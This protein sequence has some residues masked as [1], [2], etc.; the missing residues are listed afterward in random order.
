M[1]KQSAPENIIITLVQHPVF[2]VLFIPYF[3]ERQSESTLLLVEQA[4]HA[5]PER[6]SLL[7]EAERTI[8]SLAASYSE[9]ELMAIFS[10]EKVL[11]Q[12]LK[13]VTESQ[14]K[15]KIR[16]AIEKK[17]QKITELI[18]LNNIP[19]FSN[20]IGNKT[21]Y[22]YNRIDTSTEVTE[23]SFSFRAD[24]EH[25][26]YSLDCHRG[27]Q[28]VSLRE[29]K[30][31]IVINS[32]PA[33]LLFSTELHCFR[34][35]SASR[36]LPFTNKD[37]VA[38]DASLMD[39]YLE[40]I[41]LPVLRHHEASAT[42]LPLIEEK[43]ECKPLLSVG[44]TVFDEFSL[45]LLFTY[46]DKE[47][48]PGNP[49][50]KYVYL[51]KEND[52]T[53][54]RYFYRDTE[55]ENQLIEKLKAT[56]LHFDGECTFTAT[57]E[58]SGMEFREWLPAH[59]ELFT[60]E[61]RLMNQD[62]N[63]E[64]SPEEIEILE[65]LNEGNDWFE[66]YI[67][68]IVGKHRIPFNRFRKNILEGRREYL[69]PDGKFILLP[70]EW[71]SKYADLIEFGEMVEKGIRVKRSYSGIVQEAIA[72]PKEKKVLY[73]PK[74]KIT[75][76]AG[77]KATLRRYQEDGFN[78]LVHL[79]KHR[80]GGCLAD[81]M[82]LGKTLQTLALLQHL[83]ASEEK[84]PASLIV[85]PTSLLHNWKREVKKFTS[86]KMYEY[87]T[88][89]QPEKKLLKRTFDYYDLVITSYG[90]MR[91]NI[92]TLETYAFEY[93]ILDESQNIKNSDS[94]TFKA[95]VRL[96]SNFRLTLTG[97]PIENSLKDLWSQF[98][99]LQPDLLGSE[100]N[101]GKQYL[102]PV[103]QGDK[104]REQR[105]LKLITPYILRRKKEEVAPELP[106]LTVETI[107]CGM[108]GEQ[109]EIYLN[110]KNKLRNMLLELSTK[111]T[112]QSLTALN[113][114][115]KLRQLA[116]HPKMIFGDFT[117]ESGK[118]DEIISLFETLRSEGHKVLIFSSFVK[119]LEL[120]GEAFGQRGWKYALLTG[121]TSDREEEIARFYKN[122]K[123]QA[124]LISLKAGGVGLNLTQADY[125]FI[126]DPWWNPAAESQAISRAHRIG[127]DK[128]VFAYHFITE[129]SIEEKILRLQESKRQLSETFI[130]ENNP[131]EKLTDKEWA[132]ILRE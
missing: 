85:M 11:S 28:P 128:R 52:R 34:N 114:I 30:P 90:M 111:S 84:R 14:I 126:I 49:E 118:L 60:N 64:Y 10:K 53:F 107:Y 50:R 68:V 96:K 59:K 83:Y 110:E 57:N 40:N 55:K 74:E 76:P 45:R 79:N 47:F 65:E 54:L 51:N 29:R 17:L 26:R 5:S 58:A 19:L 61:L 112:H 97:T 38:V 98:H 56:G 129:G 93:V 72:C 121:S 102:I 69:L 3:F 20:K 2:G 117:G 81:D 113:G 73:H 67:T 123:I 18:C 82:G 94:Q 8:I 71:F 131:L 95:A 130:T 119:H 122:D 12:F 104:L 7:S 32:D 105:L 89:H 88:L 91:N 36:I 100:N 42:G 116:S 15:Q 37:E 24:D 4:F 106:E 23:I 62:G 21:I 63:A 66:L 43:W 101:F 22:L 25:F 109:Q 13:K 48:N 33:I 115:V 1:I 127:Q 124:F 132:E 6:L 35:I 92:D 70:E 31:V 87:N 86:L 75:Q 16:P 125:V 99:F 103:R 41:V 108:S 46:G 120:V 27:G 77:L 44:E 78:W 80:L 39:K 9:K